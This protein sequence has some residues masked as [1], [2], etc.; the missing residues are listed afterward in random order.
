[1]YYGL[2]AV[3]V[4]SSLDKN[5]IVEMLF[6]FKIISIRKHGG[7]LSHHNFFFSESEIFR[8][9][10]QPCEIK[11]QSIYRRT[12]GFGDIFYLFGFGFRFFLFGVV[13]LFAVVLDLVFF[14]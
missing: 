2:D 5:H 7:F 3:H 1:M 10:S 9:C 12:M 6:F 11:T 8:I 14:S 4:S 13:G